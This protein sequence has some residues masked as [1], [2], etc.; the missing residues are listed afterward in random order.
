MSKTYISVAL[1]QL[2]IKRADGHCE[3]CLVHNDVWNKHF[4]IDDVFIHPLTSI[5][6]VTVS[7]LKLNDPGRIRV[8]QALIEAKR[9]P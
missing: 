7:L 4:T 3:Y 6:R 8:R 1:R 2:V 5:G 9:Y